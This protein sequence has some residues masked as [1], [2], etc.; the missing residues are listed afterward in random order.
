MVVSA[1]RRTGNSDTNGWVEQYALNEASFV[2][3][4][5]LQ[6]YDKIEALDMTGRLRKGLSLTL[7]PGDGVKVKLHRAAS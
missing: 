2:M 3:A 4:K 1:L 5:I 6:R 7:S